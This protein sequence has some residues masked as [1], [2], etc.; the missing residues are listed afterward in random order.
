ME[1]ILLV[2]ATSFMRNEQLRKELASALDAFSDG[3][4]P[5]VTYLDL[6]DSS[7]EAFLNDPHFCEAVQSWLV[8]GEEVSETTLQRFP[9]LSLISK[10]GV[11]LDNIDFEACRS[12]SIRVEHEPG[13]NAL[14]VAEHALGLI[15]AITRNIHHNATLLRSGVW[16]KDGGRGLQGMKV[17]IVGLGA[18]GSRLAGLLKLLGAELS[19]CDLVQKV[20]LEN[21]LNI[22]RLNFR[23]LVIS[24]DL[25]SFHVPLTDQTYKM[26]S[27][28]DFDLAKPGLF[29][30]N[31]SR[32]GVIDEGALK[33][34]LQ[35]GKV[36]AAALDVFETEPFCDKEL[37]GT[38]NLIGTPHTAG[39]S[40]QAVEAMGRAAIRGIS[41]LYSPGLR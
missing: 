9:N 20:E 36:R 13:V 8:G 24:S 26:M 15:L 14:A 3:S 32:G 41:R 35:S 23:D 2:T 7:S 33:K 18:T 39:N 25:L 10:Y 30:V 16:N 1:P 12:R 38:D 5:K 19:Y 37:I 27:A 31:T 6:K 22:K 34:A 4:R 40:S 17:G 11:G 21:S 29:I 28:K